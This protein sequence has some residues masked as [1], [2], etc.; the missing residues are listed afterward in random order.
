[1]KAD[2]DEFSYYG[3]IREMGHRFVLFLISPPFLLIESP[4][5]IFA[6][7]KFL[8]LNKFL[9]DSNCYYFTVANVV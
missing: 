7:D 5:L 9:F 1:M 3:D 4:F 6:R 8:S 2:V